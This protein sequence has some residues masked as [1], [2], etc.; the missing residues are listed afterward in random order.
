MFASFSN[1]N[2]NF[3]NALTMPLPILRSIQEV[4]ATVLSTPVNN[5]SPIG[6]SRSA[7]QNAVSALIGRFSQYTANF[8]FAHDGSLTAGRHAHESDFCN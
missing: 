6:G 4:P 2:I 1:T 5:F 7:V 8:T 3:I